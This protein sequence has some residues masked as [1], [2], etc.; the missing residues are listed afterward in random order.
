MNPHAF[1]LLLT[2]AVL[3]PSVCLIA[4]SVP[5]SLLGVVGRP[6]TATPFALVA[7]EAVTLRILPSGTTRPSDENPPRIFQ[8]SGTVARPLDVPITVEADPAY[9]RV[10]LV[11]FTT[12]VVSRPT[13]LGLRLGDAPALTFLVL[14]ADPRP[15]LPSL[16]DILASSRLRLLVCGNSRELRAWLRTEKLDFDDQ[17][18][19]PPERIPADTLLLGLLND[20]DWARL[21]APSAPPARILAFVLAPSL[22]P[23]VYAEP[24]ARRAKITLP[25]LPLLPTDPLARETLHTLLLHSL[26]HSD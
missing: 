17:G 7:G 5:H 6:P 9:P 2:F 1:L 21:T 4:D 10:L 3:A 22:L 26:T 19:D 25:L 11:H 8:I 23:G 15:D 20:E 18:V 12:P 13:R 16:S 14:P 24:A